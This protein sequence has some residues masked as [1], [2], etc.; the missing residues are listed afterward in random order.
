MQRAAVIPAARKN[1]TTLPT[2]KAAK[3]RRRDPNDFKDP[4]KP[5]RADRSISC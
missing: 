1:K 2:L 5:A 4:N 3:I